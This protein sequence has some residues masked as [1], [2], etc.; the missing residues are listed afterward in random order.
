[1]WICAWS[2]LPARQ[3]GVQRSVQNI[4]LV[5]LI[6]FLLLSL[7]LLRQQFVYAEKIS[8]LIYVDD[9]TGQ[10]T[11]NVRRVFE[12][13]RRQRGRMFDQSGALL[14]DTKIVEGNFAVRTYPYTEQYNPAS[15]SNIVGFFSHRYLESGLEASYG[16]SQWAA[17]YLKW[18]A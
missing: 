5:V 2:V 18:P 17:R 15:F 4:G 14:V 1:M 9:Q 7:Q 3:R 11:S 6:G 10:T 13:L 8:N 16:P 12:A